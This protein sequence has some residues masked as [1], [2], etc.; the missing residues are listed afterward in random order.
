V[1]CCADTLNFTPVRL[2]VCENSRDR[3]RLNINP[4][5]LLETAIYLYK[6]FYS[7]VFYSR[8]LA[9]YNVGVRPHRDNY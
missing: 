5:S 6:K 2:Q 3:N 8:C 1:G 7:T 4:T 9:S